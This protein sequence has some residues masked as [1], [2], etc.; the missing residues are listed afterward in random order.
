MA[1][2]N[3]TFYKII[4]ILLLAVLVSVFAQQPPRTLSS[5]DTELAGICGEASTPYAERVRLIHRLPSNLAPEQLECCRAFLESPLAEQPLPDLEFNGLKNELVFA[6]LRQREGLAQLAEL[7]VRMSRAPET[8]ATW[9]DYCVQFLG[10]CYP[11]ISDA[12]SREA[13]EDALWEAL[14][15]RRSGRAAGSAARQLMTLGRTF[16]EF[17]PDK[18]AQASLEVLLD[19]ASS[20]ET[21]DMIGRILKTEKN[22]Y[23]ENAV[24]T[25]Q[26]YFDTNGHIVKTTQTALADTIYEYDELGELVCTGQDADGNGTLNLV[27]N[28]RITE[29]STTYMQDN[30]DAWWL[31]SE[32]KLYATANDATP[33]T[34][35]TSERR[36]SGFAN[37]VVSETRETDVHG[38]TTVSTTAINRA[39]KTVTTESL[40]PES[41]VAE[42]QVT[43]NG[44]TISVRSKSNLTTTFGYDGLRRRVSV[45]APRTGTSTIAY[46]AAGQLSAETD[47]AGNTTS[48]GSDNAGRLAWKKNALNKY[49]RYA[50][51]QRGQQTR[52]W[53]D[54]EYPVEY[55]YDQYG[56][57]VAMTTFRTGNAWS[58]ESWPNP[59]PVGDTTTWNYDAATGLL[60]SKVYADGYGPSYAY[61]ADG[62]LA[63]RTWARKDAQD[64]DL[65]TTYSYN[66][67]GELTGIDYS[68][69]TPD[70]TYAYNRFGKLSQV[71]DVVG[72]RTFAYNA[73]LD[74]VS[75]T[76]TGL[77]GK[78]LTRT[79][80]STGFKGRKQG[81]S[82]GNV[83]HYAYGYDSY[84]R[85]DQI[86]VPSGSFNYARLAD[87]D[88]VSQMTRPNG[89]TTT[90]SY[91]Q[92]RD[93]ITQVQNG[94]VSTYGYV[95]DAIGRRTSMSR[96]GSAHSNPD[97][98]FYNYND[99]SELTGAQSNVDATYSYSYAYD[100]IGNRISAS[101]AGLP[102]TYTTNNLNQYTS[103]TE[104]NTQ[105]SFSYDLDGSM[106][107]RPVDATSG[108]TQVWNGE[109]RMVETYRGTDRLTFKYDYMGRRVEK[110]VYSGNTLASKTLFVYDG[111]KC[112]EEL[113]ALSNN[114]VA[115]RHAWQ[116][117]DVGLDVILATTDTN[118]VSY[119]LYDA[120]KNVIQKTT[121]NGA[122][123]EKYA[124]APFG[125]NAGVNNAHIGFSS[126]V[127][128]DNT[129]ICYYNYRYYVIDMALWLK[130]DPLYDLFVHESEE[131]LNLY[132]YVNNNV[133]NKNDYFGLSN[134]LMGY[135]KCDD[136]RG[137]VVITVIEEHT[138]ESNC[139][140]IHEKKHKKN[141]QYCCAEIIKCE[142]FLNQYGKANECKPNY[143]KW[144]NKT[145]AWDECSALKAE[146]KCLRKFLKKC[147]KE[148]CKDCK[149]YKTEINRIDDELKMNCDGLLSSKMEN[150]YVTT[151]IFD[152]LESANK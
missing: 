92:N 86:T 102:W 73:T 99:R 76:I 127:R 108:W 20:D 137:I 64:N 135:T 56:Q 141:I 57:K 33:T 82:I 114:A 150:C 97:T 12:Q 142:K 41:T 72:M 21:T 133:I 101:E 125:K 54:T 144:L 134:E 90:W 49:A 1:A 59:A 51:N 10:K 121:A 63:T 123:L 29:T 110:C 113:D 77:Y 30:D 26:N 152:V 69:S 111:F 74:E 147:K 35:S 129:G 100:P 44:L 40:S 98:I 122:L 93:L 45:T 6:L 89:I 115:M 94:T 130:R 132:N 109:N 79:Y 104:S 55:S 61:T 68:D 138:T 139:V 16:P 58:G 151:L 78:T 28:D 91:E 31:R 106:T 124:Y 145:R 43:V 117:F 11:R 42:Q 107:Y 5:V 14:R 84:G 2:N 146:R 112:V 8:D 71:T 140:Y 25:Q 24:I 17:P 66:L 39:T 149:I 120:N 116:P 9:R 62:K 46:D 52:V 23:G 70:I 83:S 105:L 136:K 81:L 32:Q 67:F 95:N 37:S 4:P 119:F 22:G 143:Y 53:G 27:S 87:S 7:L 50:Y 118:G 75:E 65:V 18:V 80:T 47:A 13:M 3:T 38:N 60:T 88:L 96:T 48:C 36:I 19:P 103:A 126:E 131:M 34:V 15:T 148:E 128:D 85:M